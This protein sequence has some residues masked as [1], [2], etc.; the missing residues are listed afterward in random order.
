MVQVMLATQ[1]KLP[2]CVERV[3]DMYLRLTSLKSKVDQVDVNEY[4]WREQTEFS[5]E[6]ACLK[7]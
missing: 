3:F 2:V 7:L 1:L 4:S 5:P 6:Q